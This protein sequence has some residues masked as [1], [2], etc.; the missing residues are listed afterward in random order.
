MRLLRHV[1]TSAS[2]PSRKGNQLRTGTQAKLQSKIG[3]LIGRA[4]YFSRTMQYRERLKHPTQTHTAPHCIVITPVL[5]TVPI[6]RS[7]GTLQYGNPTIETSGADN[8]RLRPVATQTPCSP[9]HN[10]TKTGI[11]FWLTLVYYESTLL[12]LVDQHDFRP[13]VGMCQ[14]VWIG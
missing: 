10:E 14:S 8:N 12:L 11:T 5:P 7:I 3:F 1:A 9:S 13:I 6:Y 4:I 2:S